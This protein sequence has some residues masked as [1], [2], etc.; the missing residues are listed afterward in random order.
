[1]LILTFSRQ[2]LIFAGFPHGREIGQQ[3]R[4]FV[5]AV[6]RAAQQPVSL[7]V[8]SASSQVRPGVSRQCEARPDP[9]HQADEE[10]SRRSGRRGAD[11]REPAG[12]GNFD[13]GEVSVSA[14]VHIERSVVCGGDLYL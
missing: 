1:V 8:R 3:G 7:R 5:Q 2:G 12:A 14:M 10:R 9:G 6:Q 13:S 4:P 11:R